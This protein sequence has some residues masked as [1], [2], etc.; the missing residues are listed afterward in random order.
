MR[1]PPLLLPAALSVLIAACSATPAPESA[2]STSLLPLPNEASRSPATP[3]PQA[4]PGSWRDDFSTL[5]TGRWRVSDSITPFWGR[6]GLSGRFAPGNVTVRNGLLVLK[7]DVGTN[8]T[9]QAAELATTAAYGYGTYE[10]RIR[11]ASS[12]SDPAVPG[13]S[14]SGNVSALFSYVNDS[15]TE[16]DHE[17]EGQRP[18]T[19]W[20]ST[21]Q[22]TALQESGSVTGADLTQGFHTYRWDWSP[23]RVDF[24]LDGVFRSSHASVVPSAQAPLMLNLWPTNNADWGGATTPGTVYMLVDYVSFTPMKHR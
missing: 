17:I 23:T 20:M 9:A 2:Q 3:T 8:L 4:V 18:A 24:H 1:L 14:S 19:D 12:S 15:E 22:T 16:I 6:N 10:A 7:L 5:D 21:W 13:V 11:A